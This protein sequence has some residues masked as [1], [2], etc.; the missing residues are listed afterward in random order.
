MRRTITLLVCLSLI[1]SATSIAAARKS[2]STLEERR[3]YAG[4]NYVGSSSSQPVDY[5][6][7]SPV[8]FEIYADEKWADV[9]LLDNS[10]R[11]VA[12]VVA[13]DVD[14]DGVAEDSWDICGET[15]ER[16]PVT[17]GVPIEVTP[18]PAICDSSSPASATSGKI[19]VTTYR[20]VKSTEPLVKT[21]REDKLRYTSPFT[22]ESADGSRTGTMEIEVPTTSEERYFTLAASDATGL[23]VRV[24]VFLNDDSGA[25]AVQICGE[26]E[27]PQSFSA[28]T[29]L[30]LRVLP[31]PCADGTPGAASFGE[32][33]VGLSNLP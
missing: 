29:T 26:T 2:R 31:G 6:L 4:Y 21:T 17:A 1:A 32:I 24:Q 5:N 28:G 14:G 33:T 11:R 25:P 13:Q 18:Q 10:G 15:P 27:H 20:R 16:I 12:A 9:A 8:P 23:P 7:F 22:Y 30:A 19:R 3:S